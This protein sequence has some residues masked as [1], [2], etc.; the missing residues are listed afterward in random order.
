MKRDR[1]A[2]LYVMISRRGLRLTDIWW[3]S[4]SLEFKFKEIHSNWPSLGWDMKNK[5]KVNDMNGNASKESL[6]FLCQKNWRQL[7]NK[8]LEINWL[9]LTAK[10]SRLLMLGEGFQ[11][12]VV[13]KSNQEPTNSGSPTGSMLP[14]KYGNQEGDV[15]NAKLKDSTKQ[16]VTW[17][18]DPQALDNQLIKTSYDY[19]L[20]HKKY[21]ITEKQN[22]H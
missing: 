11:Y 13:R 3:V 20:L 21:I 16:W 15:Y 18:V 19:N 22:T 7:N 5:V 6:C 10:N 12:T 4:Q 8:N 14:L 2:R 1:Q 17:W 9:K